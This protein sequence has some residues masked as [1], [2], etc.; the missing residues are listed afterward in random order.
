MT[1]TTFPITLDGLD[2]VAVGHDRQ[3]GAGFYRL[4]VEVHDTGP[5]L[6]GVAADMGPGQTQILTEELHQQGAGVDIGV[7]GIAVHDEGN[8]G[9]QYSLI[10]SLIH[11]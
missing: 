11:I 8:F 9:H 4:A 6:R 2:L 3:R 10:L 1:T 7:D 5:A